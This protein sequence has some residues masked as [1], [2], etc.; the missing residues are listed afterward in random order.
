MKNILIKWLVLTIAVVIAA[1]VLPGIEANINGGRNL[2][3]LFL[4]SAAL[5]LVN[6]TLGRVLKFVTAPVNCL[7]LGLFSLIIN[8]LMLWW[9]GSMDLGFKVDGFL[10]AF[11]GSII[12]SITSGVLGGILL[13][14][15]ESKD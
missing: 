3:P 5:A 9:V 12:I 15:K 4:G 6:A 10:P 14:D 8:A 1:L 2:L 13:P 7:T 11:L